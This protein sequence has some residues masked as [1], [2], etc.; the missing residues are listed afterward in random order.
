MLPKD[1]P[2]PCLDLTS[3]RAVSIILRPSPGIDDHFMLSREVEAKCS[4]CG[5]NRLQLLNDDP[6]H[7]RIWFKSTDDCIYSVH[8]HT[9]HGFP[10]W[11][12]KKECLSALINYA[13]VN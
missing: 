11:S 12:L 8:E 13:S 4:F 2:L 10:I 1:H 3:I 5:L 7:I 6:D 9:N